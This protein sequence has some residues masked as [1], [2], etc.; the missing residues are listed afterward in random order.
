LP[1]AEEEERVVECG[2]GV[3]VRRQKPEESR[4]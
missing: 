2:K 4:E 1:P 3:R